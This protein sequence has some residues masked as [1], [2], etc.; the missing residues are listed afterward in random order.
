M[1]IVSNLNEL[2]GVA[3]PRT[4][5]VELNGAKLQIRELTV[6]GRDEFLAAIKTG[7]NA[8]AATVVRLG[9]VGPDGRQL[10]DV[11]SAEQLAD[12]S[13]K[14]VQKLAERILKL[15]GLD[16]DEGNVEGSQPSSDSS[17]A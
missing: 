17:T 7:S 11:G 1:T 15:S 6:A 13:G 14:F 9:L 5:V 3:A 4:E 8:A 2:L 10:L 16:D 12:Q